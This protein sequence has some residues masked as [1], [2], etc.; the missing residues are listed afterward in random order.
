MRSGIQ[1]YLMIPLILIAGISQATWA[2]RLSVNGVKP[3]FV[4]IIVLLW[5]LGF[6]AGSGIIWAFVG[7][8]WVDIFSGGPLGASSISLMVASLGAGGGR[9]FFARDNFIVPLSAAVL[10]SLIFA[11]SYFGILQLLGLLNMIEGT[12]EFGPSFEKIIVPSMIYNTTIM[13]VA[14]PFLGR[15][16]RLQP[17]Y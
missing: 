7:G 2:G 1:P 6:G 5:T 9:S 17:D 16:S 3:D 15:L 14:I 13:V 8:I 4:L 12:F 11:L 10:G